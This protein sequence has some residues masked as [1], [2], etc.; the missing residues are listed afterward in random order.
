MSTWFRETRI[1]WVKESVEIFGFINRAHI[2][3][4]FGISTPQAAA[5]LCEVQHRWPRLMNYNATTKRYEAAR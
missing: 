1:A 3:R 2:Q 4:K 5:D